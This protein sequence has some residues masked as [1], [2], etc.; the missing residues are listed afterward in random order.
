MPDIWGRICM[1]VVKTEANRQL[2]EVELRPDVQWM[3]CLCGKK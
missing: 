2:K 1:V 3:V